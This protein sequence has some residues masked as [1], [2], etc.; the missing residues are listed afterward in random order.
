MSRNVVGKSGSPVI[1]AL[2]C[3]TL[4]SV[5]LASAVNLGSLVGAATEPAPGSALKVYK[6]SFSGAETFYATA[7]STSGSLS[8]VQDKNDNGLVDPGE[9]LA[10]SSMGI[11]GF[12]TLPA[13]TYYLL[14]E[15]SSQMTFLLGEVA[16]NGAASAHSLGQLGTSTVTSKGWVGALEPENFYSFTLGTAASLAVSV[17]PASAGAVE[18][19]IENAGGSL[20]AATVSSTTAELAAGSYYVLV[21]QASVGAHS[22]YSLSLSA[23]KPSPTPTP[24]PTPTP[25]GKFLGNVLPLGDSITWGDQT[26]PALGGP[27]PGGYR[28]QLYLNLHNAGY[29]FNF[30][31]T[32]TTNASATLT[33]AGQTHN[34]GH[35]G[36][37]INQIQ[38]N[39]DGYDGLLDADGGYWLSGGGGTGRAAIEPNDIL[40]LIGTNDIFSH[41]AQG[42]PNHNAPEGIFMTDLEGRLAGLVNYLIKDRPSANILLSSIPP[43]PQF[44]NING[45][46]FNTEVKEY[47][48]YIQYTLVPELKAAGKHVSF[49]N[50]YANF[51]DAHG[52]VEGYLLP[53]DIHPT[54]AG[55]NAMGATWA[56]ALEALAN[57]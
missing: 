30:V 49:V 38:D 40:L 15:G 24:T 10:T 47:N 57:G 17:T 53:D 33:A 56:N 3:R 16:G 55:Y 46:P 14:A 1:E 13:G 39:L 12:R 52:N 31:G 2:E 51:I 48:A 19:E 28:T 23:G 34:E 27:I 26:D 7:S 5:S 29:T 6:F 41:V 4:M 22:N 8:L 44:N 20:L 32:V 25:S 54:Q 42:Y 50:E 11:I 9:T 45:V 21:G 43:I 35:P 36:Y 18:V 37:R